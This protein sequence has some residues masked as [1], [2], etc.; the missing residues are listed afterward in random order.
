MTTKLCNRCETI[1]PL[2]KFSNRQ[3]HGKTVKHTQCRKCRNEIHF[4]WKR[5]KKE[6]EGKLFA[7]TRRTDSARADRLDRFRG[8]V[9]QEIPLTAEPVVIQKE[10]DEYHLFY[11]RN[12]I[13]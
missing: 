3:N 13:V 1:L 5:A 4:Q 9:K 7:R 8:M 11:M 12:K 6:R 2:D 10:T